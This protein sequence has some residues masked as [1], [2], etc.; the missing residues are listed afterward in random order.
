M[1]IPYPNTDKSFLGLAVVEIVNPNITHSPDEPTL[2]EWAGFK[3][4]D[5]LTVE[6]YSDGEKWAQV[7]REFHSEEFG[8]VLA[9]DW[10]ELNDGEYKVIEE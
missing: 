5:R 6:C 9:T 10:F 3:V 4:G 2:A 1:G 8:Q 7:G